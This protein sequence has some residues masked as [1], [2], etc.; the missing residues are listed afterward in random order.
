MARFVFRGASVV[1][2]AALPH[3][4]PDAV[5]DER[6]TLPLPV[7]PV[8]HETLT[9]VAAKTT[10]TVYHTV[11]ARVVKRVFTRFRCWCPTCGKYH[12]SEV[13]GVMP[14]FMFSNDLLAQALVDHYRDG[15]PFG[16]IVRRVGVKKSDLLN[17]AHDVFDALARDPEADVAALLWG[18]AEA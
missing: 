2:A 16:T 11:P 4:R 7:C 17:A 12:E 6:I 5:A 13:P 8:T 15:I 14:R 18:K 10:R 3:R 9:D 1:E